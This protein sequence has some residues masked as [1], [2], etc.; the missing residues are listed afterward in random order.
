MPV[1]SVFISIAHNIRLNHCEWDGEW[2]WVN[3]QFVCDVVKMSSSSLMNKLFRVWSGFAIS[4]HYCKSVNNV[5]RCCSQ[6]FQQRTKLNRTANNQFMEYNDVM[7]IEFSFLLFEIVIYYFTQ[8]KLVALLLLAI[9]V[10]P[11]IK[12]NENYY[13]FVLFALSV[14]VFCHVWLI[15]IANCIHHFARWSTG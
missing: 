14:S 2:V 1:L 11:Y 10:Q 5:L 3:V 4:L 13:Y 12:W 8:S 7:C 6:R 15:H 9:V